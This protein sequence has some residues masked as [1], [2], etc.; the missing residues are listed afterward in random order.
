M[1]IHSAKLAEIIMDTVDELEQ[2]LHDGTI[3]YNFRTAGEYPKIR[4][5]LQGYATDYQSCLEILEGIYGDSDTKVLGIVKD[6]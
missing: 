1:T 5:K 6:K 4:E 2:S 3:R